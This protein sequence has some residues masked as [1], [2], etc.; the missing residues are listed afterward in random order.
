MQLT[1]N[2]E[3]HN[4]EVADD[5]PLLWVLR[6]ELG[7]VDEGSPSRCFL[8]IEFYWTNQRLKLPDSI[9]RHIEAWTAESGE[10]YRVERF[11]RPV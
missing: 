3:T 6:D 4:V 8:N 10:Q 2:G 1:V 9:E 5:M 11:R 7:C